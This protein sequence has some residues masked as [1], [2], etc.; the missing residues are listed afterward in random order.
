MPSSKYKRVKFY[1]KQVLFFINRNP[2]SKYLYSKE[3]TKRRLLAYTKVQQLSKHISNF[4][5]YSQELNPP[6][7]FYSHATT[8][9]KFLGI[10]L[11]Y[12]F[13]FV[14]EHG[15]FI[16]KGICDLEAYTLLKSIV[17][18]SNFRSSILKSC[19]PNTFAVGP[20]IHYANN[21]YHQ[22]KLEK[23]K[24]RLKN[25][26]LVFPLHSTSDVR[27]RYNIEDFCKQIKKFGKD[28]NKIRVCLYWKDVLR[29]IHKY[30]QNAGFECVTAGHAY[31]PYFLPRLKDIIETSTV[32]LT[33]YLGSHSGYCIFLNKPHIIT[34]QN[35]EFK[36]NKNSLKVVASYHN[37]TAYNKIIQLLSKKS[38]KISPEQR[39]IISYYWGFDQIKTKEELTKIVEK[40]EEIYNRS[41]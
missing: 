40:T 25:S 7:D 23:E 26:L 13:K 22:Q 24:E 6:N 17:T 30:Y 5:P 4:A 27:A 31:D 39:E 37:A 34:K 36:G 16:D 1:V 15:V 12:Q 21:L 8:L 2:L 10:P 38:F 20:Y 29:G 28:F 9:K 18:S 32:T 19:K 35:I 14:I 3:I 41:S 11:N 33:N